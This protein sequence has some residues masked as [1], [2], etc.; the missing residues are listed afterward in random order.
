MYLSTTF[1]C[2]LN[3]S[4]VSDS[5]ASLGSLFQCLT[6][7]SEKK[8]FLTFNLNLLWHITA[9]STCSHH[10]K[11][12]AGIHAANLSST[13]VSPLGLWGVHVPGQQVSMAI[14]D[15][16]NSSGLGLLSLS[17]KKGTG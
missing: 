16:C 17:L 5:T 1:K 6:T 14:P 9:I 15:L 12:G 3:T 8:H 2:F 7:L 4:R 10:S 13:Q 11:L